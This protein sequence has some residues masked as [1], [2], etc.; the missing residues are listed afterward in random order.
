MSSPST[1][2]Q[3]TKPPII[4]LHAVA[5]LK[6]KVRRKKPKKS[7]TVIPSP[8]TPPAA[9]LEYTFVLGTEGSPSRVEN[10]PK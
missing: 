1:T 5:Q 2:S 3:Q 4:S 7:L 8:R 6:T 9:S 10:P